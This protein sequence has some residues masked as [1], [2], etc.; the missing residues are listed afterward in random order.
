MPPLKNPVSGNSYR[1][2]HSYI[3]KGNPHLAG[4]EFSGWLAVNERTIGMTGGIRPRSYLAYIGTRLR[5]RVIA[6]SKDALLKG[7]MTTSAAGPGEDSFG[8]LAFSTRKR[9]YRSKAQRTRGCYSNSSHSRQ[10]NL[11]Q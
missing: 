6:T 3:D 9:S 7:G 10:S 8:R 2:G 11:S 5:S 4:D 1:V